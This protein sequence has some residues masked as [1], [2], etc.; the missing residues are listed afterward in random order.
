RDNA[1][2]LFDMHESLSVYMEKPINNT[3]HM[4]IWGKAWVKG[5]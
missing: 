5:Y 3:T 1:L 4:R 2:N